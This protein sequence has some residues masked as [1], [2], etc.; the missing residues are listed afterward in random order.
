MKMSEKKNKGKK[1]FPALSDEEID[2]DGG[3]F[4]SIYPHQF[5]ARRMK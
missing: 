3:S 4:Q 1:K 5:Q 2:K